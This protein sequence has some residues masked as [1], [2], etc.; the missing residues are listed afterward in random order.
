MRR[1]KPIVYLIGIVLILL[2]IKYSDSILQFLLMILA[3]VMP[4]LIGTAIA[5][6]LNI[7]VVRIE[8]IPFLR[9]ETSPLYKAR[10]PIS[11]LGSLIIILGLLVLVIQIVIPQMIEAF[12]V[13]LSGIPPLL[14]KAAAWVSNLKIPVPQ[15]EKW[16]NSLDVNWPQ[17]LEKIASYLT[18]SV[19]S[20]FSSTFAI[21]SRIG[22]V[23][24]QLVLSFI[25]ALYLLG[26]KERLHRQIRA[27]TSVYLKEKTCNRLR[28]IFTTANEIFTKFIIGQCTEA[29]IIG[30][31][32]A[33]GMA[34]LR[35]PYAAMVGT[36]VGVTALLPILG[37]YL[38]AFI[39]AFMVFT[40]NPSQALGFLIFIL[41]LQQVEGNLI[42]P[43]V[44]G[45]SIGLPGLWVL[46]AVTVGGGLGGITGILLAVPLTATIYRLFQKD[47]ASKQ[48]AG[49][50]LSSGM[51]AAPSSETQKPQD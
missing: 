16:L 29:L 4:I 11:M 6:V 5:Y 17:M 42:Y 3:V 21:L 18:T 28:Y 36:L 46:A 47:V 1:R 45:S 26:S 25:F 48:A 51:P 43:R 7:L 10:R 15:L 19:G 40:V 24:V 44:V 8:K 2:L 32:C 37:A 27:L 23:V 50:T 49:S 33:L 38:G 30:V 13:I 35:F 41:I 9:K 12:G 22:G 31:L 14:E 39:G 20:I 34:L